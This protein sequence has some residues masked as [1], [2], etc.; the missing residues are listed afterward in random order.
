MIKPLLSIYFV[1]FLQN[2]SNFWT[3]TLRT[4]F[5]WKKSLKKDKIKLKT[6]KKIYF[7]NL[8]KDYPFTKV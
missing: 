1:F 5:P 6:K 7:T 4:Q 2:F 3:K 8:D